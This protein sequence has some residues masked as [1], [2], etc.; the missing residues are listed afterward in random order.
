MNTL[1]DDVT[2]ILSRS[3]ITGAGA[4]ASRIVQAAQTSAQSDHATVALAMANRRAAGA[5]L[6]YVIGHEM[7]MGVE[8]IVAEGAL[9]PRE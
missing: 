3:G 5:P 4:E 6:A 7:F 9:A 2:A 8:L 1:L